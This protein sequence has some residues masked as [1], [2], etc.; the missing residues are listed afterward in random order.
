MSQASMSTPIGVMEPTTLDPALIGRQIAFQD[1]PLVD[2][3]ALIDGSDEVA[4]AERLGWAAEHV[5]FLYVSNH[6]VPQDLIDQMFEM[7]RR[8]FAQP[9]EAKTALHIRQS[10]VHRGYFPT[11]EENTDPDLTADLKE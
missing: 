1:I 2:L 10:S 3:S 8:F 11:F 7:S 6:G 9:L 5:G 4:V